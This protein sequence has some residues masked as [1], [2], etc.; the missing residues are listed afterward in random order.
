MQLL[1]QAFNI[2]FREFYYNLPHFQGNS[3][4]ES[5]PFV[6]GSFPWVAYTGVFRYF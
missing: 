3:L 2:G 5:D 1:I 4:K 6:C